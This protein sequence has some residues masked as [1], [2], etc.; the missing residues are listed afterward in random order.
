MITAWACTAWPARE[1]SAK[2]RR[3]EVDVHDVVGL[4]A[5]AEVGG[6][7]PHEVHQLRA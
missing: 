2:G 3:A 5:G 7:L 6:L 4:D 1:W